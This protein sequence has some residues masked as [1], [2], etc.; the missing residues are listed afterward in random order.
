MNEGSAGAVETHLENAIAAFIKERRSG[1][2]A[3]ADSGVALVDPYKKVHPLEKDTTIGTSSTLSSDNSAVQSTPGHLLQIIDHDGVLLSHSTKPLPEEA[4]KLIDEALRLGIG[5]IEDATEKIYQAFKADVNLH[6]LKEEDTKERVD[7]KFCLS[8]E[9][10]HFAEVLLPEV[11][12]NVLELEKNAYKKETFTTLSEIKK[13]LEASKAR[14]AKN[15]PPTRSKL[16]KFANY[17]LDGLGTLIT[18]VLVAMATLGVATLSTTVPCALAALICLI[19]RAWAEKTTLPEDNKKMYLQQLEEQYTGTLGA[20]EKMEDA[21]NVL[22]MRAE[23][24]KLFEMQKAQADAASAASAA[25]AAAAAANAA[26]LKTLLLRNE[27]IK[28][29]VLSPSIDKAS[30]HN[31]AFELIRRDPNSLTEE[32]AKNLEKWLHSRISSPESPEVSSFAS[33]SSQKHAT[34]AELTGQA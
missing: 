4:Y 26:M 11:K 27:E 32:E 21:V 18:L 5:V 12:K 29:V 20:L 30:M 17:L 23:R 19:V 28:E 15:L 6:A 3:S 22:E 2:M 9:I 16:F 31:L 7:A 25:N 33:G 24:A 13:N 10:Q 1:S 34:P 14:I 8:N